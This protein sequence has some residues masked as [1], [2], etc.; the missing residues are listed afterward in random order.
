MAFQEQTSTDRVPFLSS[1]A[2]S[3]NRV[4]VDLQLVRQ[5]PVQR[6]HS[7]SAAALARTRLGGT[8]EEDGFGEGSSSDAV[9][10]DDSAVLNKTREW[11][12]S[13]KEEIGV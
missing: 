1:A 7:L 4:L 8:L 5:S 13:L 9:G 12:K 2:E 3:S 11:P 6:C 10:I